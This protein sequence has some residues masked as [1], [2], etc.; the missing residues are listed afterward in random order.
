MSIPDP[1]FFKSHPW[2][3]G[4]TYWI[5]GD[6]SP[7]LESKKAV[8]P[9]PAKFPGVWLCGESW[10]LRQAWVEGALEHAEEMLKKL[11]M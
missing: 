3:T 6:Y 5:P 11:N 4:A 8:H 7:V 9:F 1:L 2:K 10:S